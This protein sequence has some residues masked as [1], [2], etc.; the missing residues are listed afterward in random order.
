[1]DG[2]L[3]GLPIKPVPDSKILPALLS[4]YKMLG[5]KEAADKVVRFREAGRQAGWKMAWRVVK[6]IIFTMFILTGCGGCACCCG[7]CGECVS[8]RYNNPINV[9]AELWPF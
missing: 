6:G 7:C 9:G 1:V 2:T 8:S 4:T 5:L 3:A